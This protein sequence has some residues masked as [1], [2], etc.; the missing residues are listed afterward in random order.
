MNNGFVEHVLPSRLY[1]R[2]S[3]S[4]VRNVGVAGITGFPCGDWVLVLGKIAEVHGPVQCAIDPIFDC[5]SD[6][7]E[8][9]QMGSNHVGTPVFI[10]SCMVFEECDNVARC[11]S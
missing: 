11:G 3:R 2:E 9:G 8:I 5:T 10:W 1:A 6:G 4:L 7:S